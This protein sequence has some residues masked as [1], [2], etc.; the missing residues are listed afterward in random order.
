MERNRRGKLF[1]ARQ[2]AVVS[3]QAPYGYRKVGASDGLPARLEI[4]EPEAQVVRQIFEW[5]VQEG[6]SVRQLG[7]RLIQLGVPGAQRRSVLVAIHARPDAAST[8]LLG[9][10]LL[11]PPLVHLQGD[12][13]A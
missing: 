5:H 13:T 2:G 9:H 11:Q 4:F 7:M 1:R 6:L 8:R 10:V 3:G 12:A